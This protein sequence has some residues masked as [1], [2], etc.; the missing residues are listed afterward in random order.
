MRSKF[1]KTIMTL[2]LVLCMAISMFSISAFA[3][4]SNS[5]DVVADST[6]KIDECEK[7]IKEYSE[8]EAKEYLAGDN[9]YPTLEGYL[10]AG[11]YTDEVCSKDTILGSKTPS[12]TTYA[13]FVPEHVLSIKAQISVN[14]IDDDLNNDTKASLRFITSV[15]SL[16]YK[17]VGFEVSYVGTD[18]KTY[19]ATSASNKVYSSLYECGSTTDV[20]EK[21]PADVF[22][23]LSKYFKICTLKNFTMDTYKATS[24]HVTPYWI[25]AD[26]AKVYGVSATKT[27]V[28]GTLRDEAWV[29]ASGSNIYNYGSEDHPY[30]TLDFALTHIQNGGKV[31]LIN[32]VSIRGETDTNGETGW[33]EHSKTDVT[34]TDG[35]L[36]V[37]TDDLFINDGV[38]FSNMTLQIVNN[39]ENNR[40]FNRI[41]AEGHDV[42]ISSDVTVSNKEATV[43]LFGGSTTN[44]ESTNLKVYAGSYDHICGGN[45][46]GNVTGNVNLTVGGNAS[47]LSVYGGCYTGNVLGKVNITATAGMNAGAKYTVHDDYTYQLFG[48]SYLG[49]V[50]KGVNITVKNDAKFNYIYG[51][52]CG[53]SDNETG[54]IGG[55]INID[56]AGKA[57]CIYGGSYHGSNTDT[58]VEVTGGEV[59]QV[60]GGGRYVTFEGNTDVR[61]L[62][63]T[64]HRRIYG[65]SYNNWEDGSWESP[66]RQ[67]KGYTSV[68]ISSATGINLDDYLS[69]DCA[70]IAL[71][72]YSKAQEGEWGVLI[73][74]DGLHDTYSSK[75]GSTSSSSLLLDISQYY[76]YLVKATTGGEVRSA[77][78]YLNIKPDSGYVATVY[79][80][81][82][83]V[84]EEKHYT[85]DN[86]YYQLPALSSTDKTE[87]IVE[88]IP[89]TEG[90]TDFSGYEAKINN[91]YY[92]TL[93]EAI[94]A[95][96][97][98]KDAEIEDIGTDKRLVTITVEDSDY[99]TVAIEKKYWVVGDEVVIQEG[100]LLDSSY[101]L[102]G[103]L[104]ND[105][106]VE[107]DSDG[108]YTLAA[109]ENSYVIEGIYKKRIFVDHSWWD[110]SQQNQGTDAAGVTSGVVK[111]TK[112]AGQD[113]SDAWLYL[114][115]EASEAREYG[116]VDIT[117]NIRNNDGKFSSSN[118]QVKF[119]F[120]ADVNYWFRFVVEETEAGGVKVFRTG[121]FGNLSKNPD[122]QFTAEEI[123][124]YSSDD[125]IDLRVKREGTNF[126]LYLGENCRVSLDLSENISSD[127]KSSVCILHDN[128]TDVTVPIPYKLRFPNIVVE[129]TEYGTVAVD[130]SFCDIGDTVVIQEGKCLD[131]S[132]YLAGL[133]INNK[134]V[135]LNSD[136]TYILTVEE[137]SYVIKGIYK[138]RIFQE[139]ESWDLTKQNQGTDADGVTSGKVTLPN[140]GDGWLYFYETYTDMDLTITA[141][142]DP[143][144]SGAPRTTIGFTFGDKAVA[145]SLV[146][147]SKG[148]VVQNYPSIT[149]TINSSWTD[150]KILEEAEVA[151]YQSEEG[152]GLKFRAVRKGT[153]LVIYVE[154]VDY[155][156][157]MEEA[158]YIDLSEYEIDAAAEATVGIRHEGESGLEKEIPFEFT[159]NVAATAI[160]TSMD[161]TYGTFA[162]QN[163]HNFVGD[164]ILMKRTSDYVK[165]ALKHFAGV[166]VDGE[167][168]INLDADATCSFVAA[169]EAHSVE[170]IYRDTMFTERSSSNWNLTQQN[171]GTVDGVTSGVVS[172]SGTVQSWLYLYETDGM[173]RYG[174]VDLTYTLKDFGG[175]ANSWSQIKFIFQDASGANTAV[176]LFKVEEGNGTA[177][178]KR[179]AGTA[180]NVN[181]T[182]CELDYDKYTSQGVDVR[183]KRVGTK[184]SL[185]VDGE[186]IKNLDLSAYI[187]N[188][189]LARICINC[190]SGSSEQLE[191]PYKLSLP[192]VTLNNSGNGT[193]TIT[194][195]KDTYMY[196]ETV[197]IQ[198]EA[199][200]TSNYLHSLTV[201]GTAVTVDDDGIYSFTISKVSHTVESTF[202]EKI[203]TDNENWDLTKQN[204]GTKDGVTSG[205]IILPN[206]TKDWLYLYR[207][208]TEYKEYGDIDLTLN[209]KDYTDNK[210]N[211]QVRFDFTNNYWFRFVIQEDGNGGVYVHRTG[212]DSSG[213]KITTFPDQEFEFSDAAAEAYY[214]DGIDV[215]IKRKGT[216][217]SV[218]VGGELQETF[219]LSEITQI[220][221]DTKAAVGIMHDGD[222][223]NS[224]SIEY[225][226]LF[227]EREAL[228]GKYVS[229]L[230]DGISMSTGTP[231]NADG[232]STA[233]NNSATAEYN[234][235][236]IY[237][238]E[239]DQGIGSDWT[240]LYWGQS[241][242]ANGM[243]LLVNN[244]VSKG[245]L[246][247]NPHTNTYGGDESQLIHYVPG[248]QRVE[249]LAANQG[250]LSGTAPDIIFLYMG[251]EDRKQSNPTGF[252]EKY[253][254]TL[255]AITT[256][257]P[258]AEVFCFT[259][260]AYYDN[261]YRGIGTP[262]TDS[263]SAET[264]MNTVNEA[265]KEVA[266]KYVNATV[267]DIAGIIT[268]DNYT[269]YFP[270]DETLVAPNYKAH[271]EI[272][273]IL[274]TALESQFDTEYDITLSSTE[275][276][277][278]SIEPEQ[279]KYRY[280]DEVTI[281]TTPEDENYYLAELKVDGQVVEVDSDGTYRFTVQKTDHKVEAVF[282]ERIA[283]ALNEDDTSLFYINDK[284]T[285]VADPFVLDNGDGN[286]YLY[287]T[288]ASAKDLRAYHSTDL[289]TWTEVGSVI[290]N[291]Y[292]EKVLQKDIWASEVVKD[293]DTYYMF[294]SATPYAEDINGD[295]TTDDNDGNAARQLMVA[296]SKYPDKEFKLVDFSD[297]NSCGEGNTHTIDT[298]KYPHSYAK[299]LMFEPGTY[300]AFA[301]GTSGYT[302]A[303]DPHPYVDGTDKY[304][305]WKIEKTPGRIAVV[306]MNNWLQPD[307][308]TA[309]VVLTADQEEEGK[310]IE[311]P[312]VVKHGE[313]Y[314]LTYSMGTYVDNT[315]QVG[316]AVADSITGTY[317]KLTAAEGGLL[318]SSQS[319]GNASITGA[320]HHSFVTVGEQLYIVYHRHDDPVAQGDARN[321][322]IDEVKWIKNGNGLDVMYVNGPT[323]TYQLKIM[324][325]DYTNIA[326]SAT[327]TGT[328]A[329]YLTDG[330]LSVQKNGNTTFMELVKETTISETTT[331]TFAF[332]S[333][334][335][336]AAIMVYNSKNDDTFF[337]NIS[338]IEMIGEK[339]GEDVVYYMDNLAFNEEYYEGDVVIPGSAAYAVFDP[340]N[341]KTIK[342]TIEVPEG[343][344]SVGISEIKILGK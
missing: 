203:F 44:V 29:S 117:L 94:E 218:Y 205:T 180:I 333:V 344:N 280:G 112:L 95:I 340:L 113:A 14:L 243:K 63:G 93:E 154:D 300:T 2:L 65:G 237:G 133:L 266:G 276:G 91:A 184:I 28:D 71:S 53:N 21:K 156:G 122:Y 307:W 208:K 52:V 240:K 103:L 128:D 57:Y 328:N 155:D 170:G 76:H 69:G 229:I 255:D 313:K 304:L 168:T 232:T 269:D 192:K 252:A 215:R 312:E 26:G 141:K 193:L 298:E 288:T 332:D 121:T 27:F 305:F 87:I 66:S 241:L 247:A 230:G 43:Q 39:D 134:E 227:T 90:K 136:G 30:Q 319:L 251:T 139:H 195:E 119:E 127:T 45:S 167:T 176:L 96:D 178:F 22:C 99:G 23:N 209:I 268:K 277:S 20:W 104:I 315:Y 48:G 9:T 260:M 211:T 142:D 197:T 322:A 148:I 129:G 283:L 281:V 101:Y 336:V 182:I 330:L 70:L 290:D 114:Y 212:N 98:Y 216:K 144:A 250:S 292:L 199:D 166:K 4:D 61:I 183:V 106:E 62:G 231:T 221:E 109:K 75:I 138:K 132:Y 177:T 46:S 72:R 79:Q 163:T 331:F 125:G 115:R 275:K 126:Y 143:N 217:F 33:P 67:V 214:G 314:Y 116:D 159:T 120:T 299:Y 152:T 32:T 88:F 89:S 278:I 196:G 164:K 179:V 135:E 51:G 318:L 15:D 165:E 204:Q 289:M 263:P 294:F 226:L 233:N 321:H 285:A 295:E 58:C 18:G 97:Q 80:V 198:T 187:E 12:G 158:A 191:V 341:I 185:Y 270:G 339:D 228:V 297:A 253:K 85:E 13:L 320:G 310:C 92:Q 202:R 153:D 190:Y 11:W 291:S 47:A 6:E 329:S 287:G 259:T 200:D 49:N 100:K 272:A 1:Q 24:F 236:D 41:F 19:K 334:K 249:Q 83:G 327:V 245:L 131:S 267:V 162:V 130:K 335:E 17:Q 55:K 38:I 308:S 145:I 78:E 338:R 110:L 225:K 194:P 274:Q 238:D 220:E 140:G 258:K 84:K 222:S 242:T 172:V 73:F 343:Q 337:K 246:H 206:G 213:G 201:D 234:D 279:E 3:E 302:G 108:T 224:V 316:V 54:A 262:T 309:K 174:D 317:K 207:E 271:T 169:K 123:K 265:I 150:Y 235:T 50:N 223:G 102:A 261:G 181:E 56:F 146:Q 81:V 147:N 82:N 25:T 306:K 188:E 161:E 157:V 59:Y 149:G 42:T 40:N 111:Y 175:S 326:G 60:F 68:T 244:S 324:G 5:T 37:T 186:F 160:T 256:M 257:Y 189:T 248:Y 325:S 219:E 77:G 254:E 31:H 311:A 342:I 7:V 8:A 301:G 36:D 137:S 282:G 239:I 34:I 151:Q 107:L 173:A 105:E 74:E 323:S 293:G 286:Y 303:I 171:Q 16:L 273:E 35:V 296:T 210:A 86:S 10:F 124:A 284:K 264:R 118:T 64:V